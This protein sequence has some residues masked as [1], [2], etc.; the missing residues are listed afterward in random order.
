M[1]CGDMKK[2]HPQP[3]PSSRLTFQATPGEV[4]DVMKEA[5]RAAQGRPSLVACSCGR[6]KNP[7][8]DDCLILQP[9]PEPTIELDDGGAAH[10]SDGKSG[11]D[12]IPVEVLLEWGKVF[13]MGEKK[14]G[15][16]NWKGGTKWHEFIGSALRHLFAWERGQ[17]LDS[18]SELPHLAHAIWNLGALLYYQKMKLGT[19]DRPTTISTEYVAGLFDGE[20]CVVVDRNQS[21]TRVKYSLRVQITN[22]DYVTLQHVMDRWSGG[23]T[24]QNRAPNKTV[25]VWQTTGQKAVHFLE[26]V[27]PFLHIK[28][29][30]VYRAIEFQSSLR[31]QGGGHPLSDEE[32]ATREAAYHDLQALKKEVPK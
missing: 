5:F 10:F 25:H 8:K 26:D 22:T 24:S 19:D 23:I 21:G 18:E 29:L 27:V 13:T 14:Y 31:K 20:G 9:A 32:L 6:G 7:H 28:D 17:E 2:G 1:T 15:R 3:V 4:A 11:V 12:Q 30:E 16:D